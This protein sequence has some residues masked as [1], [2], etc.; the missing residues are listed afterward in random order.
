MHSASI[1]VEHLRVERQR[2]ERLSASARALLG[3]LQAAAGPEVAV[4]ARELSP[5]DWDAVFALALRHNVAPLLQRALRAGNALAVLPESVQRDLEAARRATA[6]DNLRNFGQ[7]QQIAR[8]LREQNIPLIALKGLHLAELVYRDISLRPMGDLDILVPQPQV[9]DAIAVLATL[10]YE[11]EPSLPNGYEIK[12]THRRLN[13]LVEVHWTLGTPGEHYTPPIE[14]IW[15]SA[16]AVKLGDA[17]ARVMSPEFLL[18]HVCAHLANHHLF[19]LDFRALCDI[20]EIL[21]AYPALDWKVVVEQGRRHGW[22]R[23]VAAALR[24]A[25]DHGG[26]SVPA[27]APAAIGDD[28]LD[29]ERLADALEQLASFA[30]ISY[31]LRF[32]PNLTAL[33]SPI[34]WPAKIAMLWKRIFVPRAELAAIYGISEQSASTNL[35][36]AVRLR[37]LVRRYAASA[38]DL[39]LSGPQLAAN[40]ARNARLARWINDT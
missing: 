18:L 40:T 11:R 38:R 14:A 12:L 4:R 37:D 26:A 3:F 2:A 21:R 17:D 29:P 20:A 6:L 24:L 35:Y 19:A 16:V 34:G 7:F 23:G 1:G 30:E 31:E 33:Q 25:R 15:D 39:S 36:Y 22:R 8:A 27:D 5:Q 32:A 9:E 13:I 28:T 10:D